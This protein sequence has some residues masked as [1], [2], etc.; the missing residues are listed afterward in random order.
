LNLF[1][2]NIFK[3]EEP[4]LDG[5]QLSDGFKEVLN[6]IFRDFDKD[7]DGSWSLKEISNYIT[8][9]NGAPPN[10]Q[11]PRYMVRNYNSTRAGHL[12]FQGKNLSNVKKERRK[13]KILSL[14]LKFNFE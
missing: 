9:T 2:F 10:P 6:E 7:K 5:K 12:T 14:N 13:E 1:I 11:V 8:A 4:L 3:D